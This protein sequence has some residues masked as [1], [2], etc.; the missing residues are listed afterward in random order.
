[1][2]ELRTFHEEHGA[3]F[4][5][6]EGRSV[7]DDYGRPERTHR[8][9]RNGVGVT[10]MP[11]GVIVVEGSD[12]VSYVDNVVTNAVPHEDG[13]GCYALILDPQGRIETD[14]YIYNAN[15]GDRLLLFTPPGR[16]AA[17]A[18][19]WEVFI[20]DVEITIAS[21]EFAVFGVHGPKATEKIASVLN[22]T[23]T[24]E[25][26]LS[27]VRGS[28]R[29]HGVTVVRTDDLT[30]EEGYEVIC[31]IEVARDVLDSLVN[32][33]LNA[34]P[35]GRRSWESLTLEAGSPLFETELEG[36]I[37]NVAGVRN[38]L[39]FEKGCY[40][41]QEIVSKV[42]NRGQP[43]RRL[44]GLAV[45][46]RP[47]TGAAVFAGDTSVGEV[48]RSIDSPS[49]EQP[50]AFAYVNYDTVPGDMTVRID[51]DDV[52]ATLESLPFVEGSSVSGRLP[53][54]P[55]AEPDPA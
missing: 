52:D 40:V 38:A 13:A 22:N 2:N 45:A 32:H 48:T 53:T 47:T 19:E 43:S 18:D 5:T 24:P 50:L 27:F 6:I 54:Y 36:Q 29:D 11:Y 44:A 34:V 30:G 26:S 20:E 14:F 28:L 51:G 39:D 37:P 49:R 35:F 46:E 21:D 8:A 15:E 16:A 42:E 17:V 10:E 23:G 12:R 31:R 9:V 33:G 55:E 1:M 41:G 25:R 4:R 7:V 3:T